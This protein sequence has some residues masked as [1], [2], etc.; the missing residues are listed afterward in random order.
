V[1]ARTRMETSPLRQLTPRELET[2]EQIAQ[3]KSNEAIAESL[4]LTK[5]AV[6][7]HINAIFMKL[8]LNDAPTVSSRVKATLMFLAETNGHPPTGRP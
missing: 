7:K 1:E 8:H 2:L 5:R 6:E 3:G 4:F